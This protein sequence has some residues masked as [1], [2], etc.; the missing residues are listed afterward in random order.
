MGWSPS[1]V[2]QAWPLLALLAVAA[3]GRP[4]VARA[5]LD[6]ATIKRL[7]IPATPTGFLDDYA[8]VVPPEDSARITQI[9][10]E[11]QARSPGEIAI[12][13]LPDIGQNAPSDVALGILRYWGVGKKGNPG[14][15]LRNAGA[16]ILLVPKETSA[17]KRGQCWVST[18]NTTQ[19][20]FTDA[21][22]GDI[23]RAAV[24]YFRQQDYGAGLELVTYL[25]AQW[26][27][28]QY[29]FAL[30]TTLAAQV[31]QPST[32]GGSGG[33][34]PR[35]LFFLF[36]IV[37]VVLSSM[38]RRGGGRG[39]CLPIFIPF[40]GGW[41]GGGGWSGGG[42]GGWGGGGGGGFGGFGG[43]GGGSGGGGGASW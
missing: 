38:A 21:D 29:H 19:G 13:T 41:G 34:S 30:D 1:R 17:D 43:G 15:T 18:G 20:F 2:T 40:G 8:H 3:L 12:V 24:P 39:G 5:Q 4:A 14:D 23:C 27:A 22:A 9:A 32:E 28:K 16:V 25:T 33:I 36:I 42:G 10:Q 11:V 31:P 26:F 7:K 6:T 37:F 35:L